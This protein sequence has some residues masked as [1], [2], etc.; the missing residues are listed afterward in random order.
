MVGAILV[1]DPSS[2]LRPPYAINGRSISCRFNPSLAASR[3]FC[4]KENA[5]V[6]RLPGSRYRKMKG[7]E[8]R[9]EEQDRIIECSSIVGVAHGI[10]GCIK[11]S[12]RR[13]LMRPRRSRLVSLNNK[14]NPHSHTVTREKWEKEKEK[15]NSDGQTD[16]RLHGGKTPRD[17]DSSTS[18]GRREGNDT[19]IK[20]GSRV[21]REGEGG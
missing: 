21:V 16:G 3:L 7:K 19:K 10:F 2:L 4:L 17:S 1:S 14:Q 12:N 18:K 5:K 9:I 11:A 15:S 13:T 20:H 6:H 8:D